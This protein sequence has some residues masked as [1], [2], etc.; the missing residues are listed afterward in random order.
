[1]DIPPEN[2]WNMD[3][4]GFQEGGGRKR[5]GEKVILLHHSRSCYKAKSDGLQLVTVIECVNAAGEKMPPG[6]IFQGKRLK[7]EW[8]EGENAGAGRYVLHSIQ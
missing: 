3:E 5:N 8:Y 2:I 7:K 1:M 6:V 4:K